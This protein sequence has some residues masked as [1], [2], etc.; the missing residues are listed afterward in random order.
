MVNQ[1]DKSLVWFSQEKVNQ[2]DKSYIFLSEPAEATKIWV[3]NLVCFWYNLIFTKGRSQKVG[4][5][6]HTL[7]TRFRRPWPYVQK[8]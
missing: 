5:Q 7:H 1:I 4:V 6:P 8:G 3:C 2:I